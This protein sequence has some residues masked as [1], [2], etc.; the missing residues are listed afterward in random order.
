M[1]AVKEGLPAAAR[2]FTVLSVTVAAA[3]AVAATAEAVVG[4]NTVDDDDDEF[5]DDDFADVSTATIVEAA[6]A[7]PV[8][9]TAVVAV[10]GLVLKGGGASCGTML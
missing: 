1:G 3:A 7:G 10:V 5:N 2:L 4:I 6:V 8:E 9:T